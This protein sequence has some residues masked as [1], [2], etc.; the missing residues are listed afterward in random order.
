MSDLGQALFWL[1]LYIFALSADARRWWW[2]G[3]GFLGITL[4]LY[5]AS[6]PMMEER[7]LERRTQAYQEY[8]KRVPS[9]LIFWFRKASK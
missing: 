2:S 4:M 6:I 9:K 3:A 8:T 7:Q 1:G 5:F